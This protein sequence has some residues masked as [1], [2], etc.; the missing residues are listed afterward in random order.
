MLNI[1]LSDQELQA[2][3][4]FPAFHNPSHLSP[5]LSMAQHRPPSPPEEGLRKLAKKKLWDP[6]RDELT[7]KGK[8]RL[9]PLFLSTLHIQIT[10]GATPTSPP[11]Q[12]Y[13]YRNTI[14]QHVQRDDGTH[15]LS[16]EMTEKMLLNGLKRQ[17]PDRNP[18]LTEN[19]LTLFHHE[20]ATLYELRHLEEN[21]RPTTP[22]E[23][24]N[25]LQERFAEQGAYPILGDLSNHP[26]ILEQL[27]PEGVQSTLQL[28]VNDNLLLANPDGS[29]K[30]EDAVGKLF[31]HV[32]LGRE[33]RLLREEI[34]DQHL[35]SREASILMGQKGYFLGRNFFNEQVNAPMIHMEDI[36]WFQLFTLLNEI[37]RPKEYLPQLKLSANSLWLQQIRA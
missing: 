1:S 11:Q 21:N 3:L 18:P 34:E 28:L 29:Y 9:V 30:T 33:L 17:L 7:D 26:H 25:S 2:L 8:R 24:M 15:V 27:S 37:V 19:D 16:P 6:Q 32:L 35:L 20:F 23:L 12:F 22:D 13:G 31:H 14:I 36:E 4:C 5:F 10:M